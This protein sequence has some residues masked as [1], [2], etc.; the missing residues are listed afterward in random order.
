MPRGAKKYDLVLKVGFMLEPSHSPPVVP[1]TAHPDFPVS[2][3][4]LAIM[5][6]KITGSNCNAVWPQCLSMKADEHDLEA[7]K[8]GLRAWKE[9]NPIVSVTNR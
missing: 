6:D 5:S 8:R 1:D 4:M 7:G 2:P 3:T 9:R